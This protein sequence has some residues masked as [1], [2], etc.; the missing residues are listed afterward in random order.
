MVSHIYFCVLTGC[1]TLLRSSGLYDAV[2]D[3]YTFIEVN[4]A[5]RVHI[6]NSASSGLNLVTLDSELCQ[7]DLEQLINP[8]VVGDVNAVIHLMENVENGSQILGL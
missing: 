7:A 3:K 2:A 8:A 4:G 1:N 6:L 5:P